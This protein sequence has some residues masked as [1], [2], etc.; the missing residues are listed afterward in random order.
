MLDEATSS[1]DNR[2]E[3]EVMGAINSLDRTITMI[4]IAQRLSAVRR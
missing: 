4:L 1:L 2:T 3:A